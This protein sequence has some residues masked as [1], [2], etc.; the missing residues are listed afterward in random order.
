M[1][2]KETRLQG[3]YAIELEKYGDDRGFFARTFCRNE[4]EE[5]E[6]SPGIVQINV[7]M[8]RKRGTL[9]GL[10]FQRPPHAE[11]K[12]IRCLN[13][14]VFDVAVDLRTDSST[15]GQW[16][17]MILDSEERNMIHIPKGCAHG[18][19]TLTPDVELLYCHSAIYAPECEGGVRYNDPQLGIQ[20]PAEINSLSERDAEL[21]FFHDVEGIDL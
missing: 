19:L 10:H 7:S 13:G 5:H 15:Y 18:F 11:D 3:T 12:T 4:F 2:F 1:T 6:L 20:W 16:V 14:R 21:P 17:A 8:T 9:R